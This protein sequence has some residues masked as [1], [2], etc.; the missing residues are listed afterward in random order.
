[1]LL[2]KMRRFLIVSWQF[3]VDIICSQLT[4]NIF[5]VCYLPHIDYTQASL[6]RTIRNRSVFLFKSRIPA[7]KLKIPFP[8]LSSPASRILPGS[9]PLSP[10]P[11]YDNLGELHP[12]SEKVIVSGP[13]CLYPSLHSINN[14]APKRQLGPHVETLP[15]RIVSLTG[16]INPIAEKVKQQTI[17]NPANSPKVSL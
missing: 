7:A 2:K 16:F 15:F 9:R 6:T 1:M 3:K 17:Q 8:T 13:L 5:F 10:R 11:Q 12:N 14:V 4:H